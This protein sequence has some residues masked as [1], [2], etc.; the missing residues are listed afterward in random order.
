MQSKKLPRRP[1]F[2]LTHIREAF[3]EWTLRD[4]ELSCMLNNIKHTT[5]ANRKLSMNKLR[6]VLRC[7]AKRQL[8]QDQQLTE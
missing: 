4:F 2:K 6:Q 8:S 7:H 1:V 5:D 3:Q